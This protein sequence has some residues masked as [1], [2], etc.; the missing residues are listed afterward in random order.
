VLADTI[1]RSG[2]DGVVVGGDPLDGGDRLV[3]ALRARL[4]ARVTIMGGFF[5]TPRDV[6]ERIGRAGHGMYVTTN[7]LPRGILPLSAAGRRFKRDIGDPA[8]Q[9]LGVME[10]GQATD[11]VLDA[12]A[13]S[14]GTR[15]SVLKELFASEVKDGILGS[16]GF[17]PNG[18]IR[19]AS[20]PILRVTG[21]TP[22]GASLP[23]DFQGATL[24]RVVQVP[25]NLVK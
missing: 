1:A 6:V 22:P 24:D 14:D 23:P 7:D 21:A 5:F 19:P 9:Y 20:I 12:I 15:A 2:A 10:A 16:F 13:R 4:G 18:D 11:L 3:K 17:D 25:T 8:T